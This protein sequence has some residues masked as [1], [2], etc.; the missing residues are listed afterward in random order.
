MG[1]AM[2]QTAN[3]RVCASCE[4]IFRKSDQDGSPECPDCGFGSYGARY[5]YGDSA[6]KFA[7]TQEPWMRNK[8]FAEEMKLRRRM[9]ELMPKRNNTIQPFFTWEFK[10]DKVD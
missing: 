6:Y 3:L 9:T 4:F 10:L 5:V 1:N 7:E 2:S 8:L